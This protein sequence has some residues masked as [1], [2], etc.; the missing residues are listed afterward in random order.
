[1][2]KLGRYPPKES[3]RATLTEYFNAILHYFGVN[4]LS[5]LTADIALCLRFFSEPRAMQIP[6]DLLTSLSLGI[7]IRSLFY[8]L[9][10]LVLAS[11]ADIIIRGVVFPPSHKVLINRDQHSFPTVLPPW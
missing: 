10:D 3:S 9:L 7:M 11:H 1:M 5:G 2:L 8:L 4:L 6:T